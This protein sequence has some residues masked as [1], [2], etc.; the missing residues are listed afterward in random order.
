MGLGG[1]SGLVSTRAAVVGI[2]LPGASLESAPGSNDLAKAPPRMDSP[3]APL[4]EWAP[5]RPRVGI[6]TAGDESTMNRARIVTAISDY[7]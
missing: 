7:A 1:S 2:V 5:L 6:L 4:L 3:I